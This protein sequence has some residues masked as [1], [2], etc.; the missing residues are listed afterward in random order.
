MKKTL[1]LLWALVVLCVSAEAVTQAELEQALEGTAAYVAKTVETPKVGAIGG[2]WAVMGLAR[3][4]GEVPKGYLAAVERYVKA[5]KGVL[6]EK[7]YTEYAR[8]A[9]ALTAVGEDPRD[10]AGYDLLKP[11]ENYDH[12]TWQGVNG[13]IYALLALD[14][15]NYPSSTR[16]RY[17]DY[18]LAAQLPGGGW[19]LTGQEDTD[20]TA[21]ALQALAKYQEQSKVKAATE[22]AL[23]FFAAQPYKTAESA[24]QVVVALCELGRKD[25]LNDPV[26]A[27]LRFRKADGSFVHNAAGTG[28]SQM[29]TEQGLYALAAAMRLAKG[30]PSLYRM[31]AFP[32]T[33]GHADNQ[34]IQALA[35]QGIVNGRPDGNFDPGA[36]LTRGEFAAIIV[37]ALELKGTN[38]TVFTDVLKTAWYAPSVNAA[39]AC[40]IVNGVGG[41]NFAPEDTIT[42]AHALL[43][44]ERAAKRL[45]VEHLKTT[46]SGNMSRPILRCE[47]ARLIYGLLKQGGA[48]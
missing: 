22:K 13:P 14:A 7:K 40:G 10:V 24:A 47:M 44:V 30:E 23:T 12:V 3:S 1:C 6:H 19:S 31:A 43:M 27:L 32:D 4:G 17:V 48:L 9:L 8:V 25:A 39:Y 45:G 46:L 20:L 33:L 16:Q 11:L 28:N 5:C 34:A 15:A 38:G 2:E 37:R 18:L 42:R 41:G 26:A 29:A 36:T 21:M 35:D